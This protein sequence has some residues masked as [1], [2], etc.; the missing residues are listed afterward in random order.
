MKTLDRFVTAQE[1]QLAEVEAELR[2]GRKLTHWMWYVFPQI[3]GL[4][5]SAQSK[6]YAIAD[7]GE[8]RAYLA[9]PTLGAR[10]RQHVELVIASER[11]VDAIFGH[12]D[13][14]KFHSS[15]TLFDAVSPGEVFERALHRHFEGKRDQETLRLLHR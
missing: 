6:H 9:H 10:L 8:A 12:P 4:G 13:D 5:M 1:S 14:L 7:L 15:V 3:A 2:Q 11:G